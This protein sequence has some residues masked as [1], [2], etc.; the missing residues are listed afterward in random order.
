MRHVLFILF[1]ASTA[2]ADT[3]AHTVRFTPGSTN[4]PASADN[5]II[6]SARAQSGSNGI[7]VVEGYASPS[8]SRAGNLR[9]S[10]KRTEAVRSALLGAGADPTRIVLIAHGEERPDGGSPA[11]L[12]VIRSDSFTAAPAASATETATAATPAS[13]STTPTAQARTSNARTR[14]TPPPQPTAPA[15]PATTPAAPAAP[16]IVV[17]TPSAPAPSTAALPPRY[18]WEP[19]A[20]VYIAPSPTSASG[21]PAGD[22]HGGTIGGASVSPPGAAI[23]QPPAR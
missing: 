9:L 18:L 17:V 7:L 2:A 10:Q 8:G 23:G 22:L 3:P 14:S 19:L 12:V 6:A 5:A 1:L 21:A 13:P 15:A 16:T 20:P 4:V 11:P